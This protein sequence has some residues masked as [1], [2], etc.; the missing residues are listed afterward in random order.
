MAPTLDA[1]QSY[2]VRDPSPV[3]YRTL[4]WLLRIW[5]TLF[6]NE[7]RLLN[8]EAMPGSGAALL[9][10]NHPASLLDALILIATFDR[11]IRCILDRNQIRGGFSR[12]LASV[13][14]VIPFER[15]DEGWKAALDPGATP[16]ADRAAVMT[17]AYPPERPP[18]SAVLG[19]SQFALFAAALA[20][21][22]E[23]RHGGELGLPIFP[24]HLFLP[25][26]P[27]RSNEVLVS[28]D[29]PMY[30]V[31]YRAL[32]G[33]LENRTRALGLALEEACRQNAFRLQPGELRAFM[34][35]LESI[36]RQRLDHEW[37]REPHW[38]QSVEGFRL[39]R[40]L[41]RALE[42]LNVIHPGRIVALREALDAWRETRRRLALQDFEAETTGSWVKSGLR[43]AGAW[44]ETL[45]GA[46]IALYGLLNHLAV[47]ALLSLMGFMRPRE[48]HSDGLLWTA[49]A[50]IVLT[51]YALQIGLCGHYLGRAG[52]GYYAVTLP[53][54]GAVL[55]R[56][57]WL[58]RHRSRLLFSVTRAPGQAS[59]LARRQN[60][61]LDQ[62][63]EARD[64]YAALI[65]LPRAS[66]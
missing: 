62:L 18:K 56:F 25:V 66:F 63:N 8:A 34:A 46:P 1:S 51:C 28:I 14:G 30:P 58:F 43:R 37:S 65:G 45:V 5:F 61:F 47:I 32:G 44:L 27:S 40:F 26:A 2:Q 17:F 59:R 42:E 54:S 64:D 31:D 36:F 19:P 55:M 12:W 21:E 41:E 9:L 49:R 20:M 10:V 29:S 11:P 24:V 48:N 22:A 60:Q 13:M 35:D 57:I 3:M 39:S 15:N 53:F 6:F 52:A 33:A 16:L 23:M 7:I 50:A 38:K 4:R